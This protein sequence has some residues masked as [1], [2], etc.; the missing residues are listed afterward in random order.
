[1]TED[2]EAAWVTAD[3]AHRIRVN[4]L[5]DELNKKDLAFSRWRS[6][7]AQRPIL[8]VGLVARQLNDSLEDGGKF[9]VGRDCEDRI[10]NPLYLTH[11]RSV[12]RAE[13]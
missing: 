2:A 4:S 13:S 8:R 6:E 12:T 7:H 3:P 10:E 1:M 11:R 9:Q 5:S